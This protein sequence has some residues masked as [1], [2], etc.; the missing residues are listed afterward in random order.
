MALP[1]AEIGLI[2]TPSSSATA[3]FA[4]AT[5][6]Y[7]EGRHRAAARLARQ[8]LA[9][10]RRQAPALHLLGLIADQAGHPRLALGLIEQA[11]ALDWLAAPYHASLGTVLRRLGQKHRAA[12]AF[13]SALSLA[14][15]WSELQVQAAVLWRELGETERAIEALTAAARRRPDWAEVHLARAQAETDLGRHDRAALA[16]AEAAHLRPED[17]AAWTGLGFALRATGQTTAALEAFSEGVRQHPDNPRARINLGASLAALGQLEEAATAYREAIRLDPER[18]EAHNNL[19][20]V[21]TNLGRH[22]EALTHF[23]TALTIRPDLAEAHSNLANVLKTLWRFDAAIARYQAALAIQPDLVAARINLGIIFTL[24]GRADEAFT[25]FET[26]LAGTPTPSEALAIQRSLLFCAVGRDDLDTAHLTALHRRFGQ[27]HGGH[28]PLAPANPV[29]TAERQLKIGYLSSEFR[30][31]PVAGN[32]LPVLRALDRR[33]FELH[34]YSL[35]TR[36]DSVTHEIQGL[37]TGWH[38]V[39]GLSDEAIAR[40]IAG[41]GIDIL[42]CLAG[43]FDQNQPSV[44]GWRAAPVQISLH[45]VATSG[46][47]EMDYILGDRWLL[48]R[49]S[50]EYFSERPLRLP[51]FYLA[52]PPPPPPPAPPRSGPAVF[53]CFNNPVKIGPATLALW[54]RLLAA[55]PA[56]RLVLKYMGLYGSA[57]LQ[58]RFRA[59]L[60]AAGAAPDQIELIADHDDEAGFLARYGTVDLAL[61]PFPFSGSTTSFQALAMGVPV[62]TWPWPR[63]IGRWSAAMLHPLGLEELIADSAEDYLAR[64]CAAADQVESWRSRREEIRQRLLAS[65]LCDGRRLTRHLERLYRATWRRWAVGEL[66]PT[67]ARGDAPDPLCF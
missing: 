50:P 19:G 23:G 8:S 30:R 2:V 44:A 4:E 5:R 15:D 1:L 41:D 11:V 54:G 12:A 61:D 47:A 46:L 67:P 57:E 25:C 59:G 13:D 33:R 52:D 56:C 35:S 9:Q 3:L 34:A 51:Q 18:F 14:P 66:P 43:H 32:L 21:L 29:G 36:Q 17:L 42:I 55:R 53:C 7:Q 60:T 27:R 45:D 62:I 10:D 28:G 38:P 16:F 63:M 26:A 6:A 39:A 20:I 31:H 37:V 40:Q 49:H 48:P 58:T 64:A 24:L 22:D 65:P